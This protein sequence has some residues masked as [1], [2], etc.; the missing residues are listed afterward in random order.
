MAQRLFIHAAT[1]AAV[2]LTAASLVVTACGAPEP[3][4][5]GPSSVARESTA[6]PVRAVSASLPTYATTAVCAE[7][8]AEQAES[9]SGSHHDLAMRPAD[10]ESVLGDFDDAEFAHQGTRWKFYRRDGGYFV[11][12]E[13]AD[14]EPAQFEILY[15]FGVEPLQQ[16]LVALDGGRM[17]ALTAA[18]DSRPQAEGGG[19]WFSL[20]GDEKIDPGDI[21]H[22]TGPA[23]QWNTMCAECHSTAYEKGYD[24]DTRSYESTWSDVNVG[25]EACHGAGS[26]HVQWAREGGDGPHNGLVRDLASVRNNWTLAPNAPI[27]GSDGSAAT[28]AEL[29]TCAPCHSRR[30]TSGETSDSAAYLDRYRPSLLARGLY[31][32]DGQ[33]LDEVYVW[34]SFLQS[35]MY[36]AGVT[37]SDCHDPHSLG[38]RAEGNAL[39]G[40]CHAAARYDSAT[41]HHHEENGDGAQCVGCHMPEQTYM[42]IDPRRDH[43]FHVPR[44][45]LSAKLGVPNACNTCHT[46]RSVDWAAAEVQGWPNVRQAGMPHFAEPLARA[47][48]GVTDA[49]RDLAAVVDNQAYPAIVRA[50]ALVEL[51]NIDPVRTRSA[52]E[53]SVADLDPLV[54]YAAARAGAALAPDLRLGILLPLAGDPVLLVRAEVGRVLAGVPT[55][56]LNEAQRADIASA[57]KSYVA[58]ERT[59][60]DEPSANVNLGLLYLSLEDFEQAE[61]AYLEAL[62]VGPHFLPGYVNL[63]D[64]YRR[65]GREEE[66]ERLL[67]EALRRAPDNPEA[68]HALGLQQ[69]RS[70][71]T[72]EAVASLE[73]AAELAP[74]NPRFTYVYGVALDSLGRSDEAIEVLRGG[75]NYAPDNPNLLQALISIS[76]K[77]GRNDDARRYMER[78]RAVAPVPEGH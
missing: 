72:D 66:G 58:S 3:N 9:W 59:R 15:T 34:G 76:L 16:Y 55:M 73:R 25:C 27:A 18:W 56:G 41:H 46:D 35:R 52:V 74:D 53:R 69:I 43:G 71:R 60:R 47:R 4:S 57:V 61:A 7:C 14:G 2:A 10:E 78:F 33:I 38:L 24:A 31:H 23:Q 32:P 48:A 11:E 26:A 12:T 29:E 40:N 64:L 77:L 51:S 63:A 67:R 8:H 5:D 65:T 37:C 75:L 13:G 49:A 21:L 39:C 30:S 22:W 19:R 50:T 28:G 6:P 17:H 62:A 70:K 20:H 42:Q 54:R 68:H 1:R 45:D 36:A 44:P